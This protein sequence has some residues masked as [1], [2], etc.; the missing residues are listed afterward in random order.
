MMRYNFAKLKRMAQVIMR[1]MGYDAVQISRAT[2]RLFNKSPSFR[3]YLLGPRGLQRIPLRTGSPE[4]LLSIIDRIVFIVPGIH[5]YGDRR[6]YYYVRVNPRR[7]ASEGR[8]VCSCARARLG[9]ACT[10]RLTVLLF[11]LMQ[12][13][14]TYVRVL[15][16]RAKEVAVVR[17]GTCRVYD[18]SGRCTFTRYLGDNVGVA[19][20]AVD[21]V[22]LMVDGRLWRVNVKDM[23]E[24]IR[25]E[26]ELRYNVELRSLSL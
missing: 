19:T 1:Q 10:H 4:E 18:T 12:L 2:N 20:Y 11:E 16:V 9:G 15:N 13:L 21:S 8:Y 23:E 22:E 25:Y 26:Y 6:A 24:E 17:D 5:E 7:P 14:T 3:L